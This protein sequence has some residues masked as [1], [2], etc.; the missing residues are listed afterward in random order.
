MKYRNNCST[1]SLIFS[2]CQMGE[3]SV[4][5]DDIPNKIS[6]E[7]SIPSNYSRLMWTNVNYI[8]S[9]TN[10]N[11]GYPRMQ[12]SGEYRGWFK[13]QAMIQTL[14]SNIT[15]ALHSFVTIAAWSDFVNL[16]VN[17]YYNSIQLNS[18]NVSLNT[19]TRK[20]L[21]LNW[22]G[23]NKIV[24]TP[25]GSGYVDTGIDDLCITF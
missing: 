4:T 9:T 6:T 8:N 16:T 10:S 25:S 11:S 22:Y 3:T 19:T 13:Y 24:L 12:S 17:G 1:C 23:L 18:I 20:L 15:I 14:S 21:M 2:V 5:F 7:D